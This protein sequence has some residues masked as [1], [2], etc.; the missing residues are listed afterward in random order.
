MMSKS[1]ACQL[2]GG[3]E[4]KRPRAGSPFSSPPLRKYVA[5]FFGVIALAKRL[6]LPETFLFKSPGAIC[7][8]LRTAG[9]SP[10]PPRF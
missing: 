5:S 1:L 7:I 9:Q 8:C 6:S 10:D 3:A 4:P 2:G